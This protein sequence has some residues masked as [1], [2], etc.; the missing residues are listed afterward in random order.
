MTD[1]KI[2]RLTHHHKTRECEP[3]GRAVLL[4]FLPLQLST[5]A[6]LPQKVSGFA[7]KCVS[8]D[9]HFQV[10]DKRVLGEVGC[11]SFL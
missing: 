7:S 2:Q 3:H 8:W 4:G 5:W 9:I 1:Q 11:S 6:P 10:L